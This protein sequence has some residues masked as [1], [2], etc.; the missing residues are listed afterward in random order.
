MLLRPPP[1]NEWY[2]NKSRMYKIIGV[3]SVLC[4]V[5]L[6]MLVFTSNDYNTSSLINMQQSKPATS[7]SSSTEVISISTHDK[8]LISDNNSEGSD[9]LFGPGEWVDLSPPLS[10]ITLGRAGWA[11]IHQLAAMYPVAPTDQQRQAAENF[12]NSLTVLYPCKMCRDNF[13]D[14]VNKHPVDYTSRDTFTQW[15][16]T[17]HNDVN[18]RTGKAEKDCSLDSIQKLWPSQLKAS[19]ECQINEI[20]S[21]SDDN[22]TESKKE[23]PIKGKEPKQN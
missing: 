11:F 14:Y 12:I 13:A 18:K 8:S 1:R 15:L 20:D 10:R 6:Y 9:S 7:S 21:D 23:G 17:A 4:I 5:I 3:L 16:C 19:C 22:T 2:N